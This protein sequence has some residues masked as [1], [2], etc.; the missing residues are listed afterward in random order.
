[1]EESAVRLEDL[2]AQDPWIQRKPESDNPL[3]TPPEDSI[4]SYPASARLPRSLL[5][6]RAARDAPSASWAIVPHPM[7]HIGARASMDHGFFPC[8]VR[9]AFDVLVWQAETTASVPI[10]R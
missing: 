10:R 4:E 3:K 2:P 6:I 8:V 5:D 9:D 1:M 7:R